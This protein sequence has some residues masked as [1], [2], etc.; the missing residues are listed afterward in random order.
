MITYL[1]FSSTPFMDV[2][3]TPANQAIAWDHSPCCGLW[4]WSVGHSLHGQT[5][6][7]FH[8]AQLVPD[9]LHPRHVGVLTVLLGLMHFMAVQKTSQNQSFYLR[10]TY[11]GFQPILPPKRHQACLESFAKV[12]NQQCKNH[13]KCEKNLTKSSLRIFCFHHCFFILIAGSIQ[14]PEHAHDYS[15]S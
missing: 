10:L 12:V 11:G 2:V 1:G 13:C 5:N 9:V 7:Y 3:T 15:S 6:I 8:S 14:V 4:P